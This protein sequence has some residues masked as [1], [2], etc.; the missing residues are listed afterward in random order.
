MFRVCSEYVQSMFRV[1]SE[2]VQSMFRYFRSMFR[3]CSESSAS[4]VSVFGIF[5]WDL[6]CNET[7]GT[8]WTEPVKKNN[9]YRATQLVYSL[10][11][12]LSN[13]ILKHKFKCQKSEKSIT[14]T[15][16]NGQAKH[17]TE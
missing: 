14:T 4:N 3:L 5:L 6:L 10:K 11:V 12:E 8:F 7:N 2:Y 17:T 15:T 13:A 1:C 9:L 16:K